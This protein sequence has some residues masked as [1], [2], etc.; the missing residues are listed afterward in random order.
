MSAVGKPFPAV[1]D[2]GG[3]ACVF[4]ALGRAETL[5]RCGLHR[6]ASGDYQQARG[7]FEESVAIEPGGAQ[8]PAAYVWLG[9]LALVDPSPS[10]AARA[11]AS[12]SDRV[13]SSPSRFRRI[14]ST[15][16]MGTPAEVA[17]RSLS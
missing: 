10:A 11:K 5:A 15:A 3:F 1:P 9:E 17:A 7:A 14:T 6:L 12:I 8:A 16:R 13:N 2:P 4:V